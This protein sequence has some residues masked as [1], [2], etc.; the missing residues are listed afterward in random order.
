MTLAVAEALNP[1]KPNQTKPTGRRHVL[2]CRLL[3]GGG[4]GEFW[5]DKVYPEFGKLSQSKWLP[6]F[7]SSIST[8][9]ATLTQCPFHIHAAGHTYPVPL[10]YPRSR[11][12]LPSAPS[13]STQQATL[14]QCLF[15]IHAAGH[16]YPVPLPYPRSRPHLPSAPSISTQQAT[17]TQCPF[18]IHAAGHTYPVPL[19]Y[20]RSRPHLPSA[21]SISTQQATLTQ[22]PLTLTN[23]RELPCWQH[24][25]WFS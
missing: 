24:Y 20:P 19:P 22:C 5:W 16:T 14:T 2:Q 1:N 7:S 12:H 25:F 6:P 3:G 4:S 23:C 10:P 11:P 21:S 17:L 13:I 9:Q 15:H 8:Q 18:H